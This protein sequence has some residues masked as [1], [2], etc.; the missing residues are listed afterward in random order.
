MKFGNNTNLVEE[1][2][3]FVEIGELLNGLYKGPFEDIIV[4]KDFDKALE[5]AWSQDLPDSHLPWSD[6]REAKMGEVMEVRYSL[7]DFNETDAALG[8]LVDQFGDI[9]S[10]RLKGKHKELLDEVVGDMYNAAYSRAV[11]GISD[12]LLEQI[13]T[14]YKN[15]GWPCG[16]K[17]DYPDGNLIVYLPSP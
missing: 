1:V 8:K 13:F 3:E 2:I 12:N 10:N 16:F 11:N 4:E 7:S 6:L 5:I 17:G 9:L 15:G 14:I